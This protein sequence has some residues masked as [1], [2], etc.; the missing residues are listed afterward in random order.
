MHP[1][2]WTDTTT[3]GTRSAAA[4][5]S[6]ARCATAAEMV[7]PAESPATA[8]R[9]G[10]AVQFR[11]VLGDPKRC[12][13]SVFDGGGVGV[14]GGQSVVDGYHDRVGADR[15]L[16]RRAVVSVEVAHDEAAAVEDT[17][18]P[19][20]R[21]RP[22]CLRNSLA[23][24]RSG[25]RSRPRVRRIV[26]SST[27]SSGCSGR[28]GRSRNRWRAAPIPSS[29]DSRNGTASSTFC[30]MGSIRVSRRLCCPSWAWTYR[31]HLV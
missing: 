19:A 12:G 25:S 3:A 21:R 8:I 4:L 24:N 26:R 2:S 15:M 23:A 10:V 20:R 14:L 30:R 31:T 18:R 16:T 9:L 27:R 22:D 13:P 7:P 5:L 11:G 1:T 6:R 28:R 29:V 17:A